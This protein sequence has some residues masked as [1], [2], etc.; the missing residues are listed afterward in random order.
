MLELGRYPSRHWATILVA[1]GS[2][3]ERQSFTVAGIRLPRRTSRG[4]DAGTGTADE[5][6]SNSSGDR[7]GLYGGTEYPLRAIARVDRR[8]KAWSWPGNVI[9]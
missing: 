7:Q 6:L 5:R 8:G 3:L 9:H 2:S 1:A 4:T